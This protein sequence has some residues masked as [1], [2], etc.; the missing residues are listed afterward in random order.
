M[1]DATQDAG[2]MAMLDE[3]RAAAVRAYGEER[4]ADPVLRA[5]LEAAATAAGRV[6]A[7]RLE[8]QDTAPERERG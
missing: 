8:P 5:A 3:L 6:M 2:W 4:A 7:E 1:D